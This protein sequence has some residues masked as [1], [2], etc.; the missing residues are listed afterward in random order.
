M[1]DLPSMNL[2]CMRST[3]CLNFACNLL[4]RILANSFRILY[5]VARPACNPDVFDIDNSF[6]VSKKKN[7]VS[8]KFPCGCRHIAQKNLVPQYG[9]KKSK[10]ARCRGAQ[11]MGDISLEIPSGLHRE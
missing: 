10:T 4:D 9:K 3:S 8:S 5:I 7:S 2:D 11:S 1:M 6:L